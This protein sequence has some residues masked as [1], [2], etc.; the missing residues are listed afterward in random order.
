MSTSHSP[1][2]KKRKKPSD[3]VQKSTASKKN[4]L[5]N[6]DPDHK[7]REQNKG[8]SKKGR[9]EVAADNN[10]DRSKK[11]STGVKK[12]KASV[13]EAPKKKTPPSA[14]KKAV[15]PELPFAEKEREVRQD[16]LEVAA[17]FMKRFPSR[18]DLCKEQESMWEFYS[19]V[20]LLAQEKM[21]LMD[22]TPLP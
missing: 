20:I 15:S 3:S 19:E 2:P 11:S 12:E 17:L 22:S 10:T 1:N 14:K 5:K 9:P 21:L 16:F 6:E 8:A 7:S 13:E 18:M 4:T